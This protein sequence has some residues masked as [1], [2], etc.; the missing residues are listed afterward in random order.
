M[1]DTKDY[2]NAV[3]IP[4]TRGQHTIIDA[5]DYELVSQ[6][7]WYAALSK[8]GKFYA[9]RGVYEARNPRKQTRIALHQFLLGIRGR[10]AIGDHKSGD[11]LDNRRFNLR[12][13]N[14]TQN[15]MNARISTRNKTGYR[16][17]TFI[18]NRYRVNIAAYG[19]QIFVGGFDNPID[20]A[21]A[22]DRAAQKI[23]G[24]YAKLNF[25]NEAE[26]G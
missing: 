8:S 15:A 12:V 4:L 23:H 1:S 2:W 25:P 20:A 18:Q 24:E 3:C 10:A 7:K 14:F 26:H 13:V 16:G 21:R 5:E 19:K 17:V 11:S 9:V 6:Y 22:Y